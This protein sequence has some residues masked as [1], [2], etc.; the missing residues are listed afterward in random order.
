MAYTDNLK[1]L[2]TVNYIGVPY[3]QLGIVVSI[4]THFFSLRLPSFSLKS[5]IKT[6]LF[7]VL[8]SSLV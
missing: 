8:S 6:N 7:T 1:T 3:L 5:Q 2:K 4:E